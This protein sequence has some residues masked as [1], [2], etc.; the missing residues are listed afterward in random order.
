MSPFHLC[1]NGMCLLSSLHCPSMMYTPKMMPIMSSSR[2]S[3]NDIEA[4][5]TTFENQNSFVYIS[6]MKVDYSSL[7][8]TSFIHKQNLYNYITLFPDACSTS[9]PI[10]CFNGQC[11]KDSNECPIL[12][13][14]NTT[15]YNFNYVRCDDGTCQ[16]SSSLCRGA[17]I[18]VAPYPYMCKKGRY[19]GLCVDKESSCLN[20]DGIFFWRVE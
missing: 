5:E 9:K 13:P 6:D 17:S 14:C 15:N 7:A 2:S 3:I 11:V 19:N 20:D 12:I 8:A 18:C 10:R 16:S 4:K 1:S